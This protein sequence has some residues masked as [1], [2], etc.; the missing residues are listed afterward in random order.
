M[1][2]S[3]GSFNLPET[4]AYRIRL[5]ELQLHSTGLLTLCLFGSWIIN[6]GVAF[7]LVS[8]RWCLAYMLYKLVYA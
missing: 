7:D 6:D 1:A 8:D 4:S 2:L 3:A 5:R